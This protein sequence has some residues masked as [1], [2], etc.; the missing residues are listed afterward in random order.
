MTEP[1]RVTP[2][3]IEDA[4]VHEHYFTALNGVVGANI[5][6]VHDIPL[7][8]GLLTFCVLTLNNNFT[9]VGKSAC[10][11]PA[12]YNKELG[13]QIARQ[14]AVRQVWPLL[15]FRLAD[16]IAQDNLKEPA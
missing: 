12:L 10:V 4:I 8:L 9:V 6:K 14:D 1:R 5:G 13:Q 2:Q 16:R 15:G 7:N 3:D 11:D